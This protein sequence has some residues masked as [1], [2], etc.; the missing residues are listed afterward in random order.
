M[1][2]N[3]GN[4]SVSADSLLRTHYDPSAIADLIAQKNPFFGMLPKKKGMT[5]RTV[6]SFV[7]YGAGGGASSDFSIAQAM[8]KI[9]GNSMAQFAVPLVTKHKVSRVSADL[10]EETESDVGAFMDAVTLI[11]DSD[12]LDFGNQL[13]IALLRGTSGARGQ[14]GSTTTIASATLVLATLS[15]VDQFEVGQQL[16]AAASEKTGA[17]RPLGSNGHGLYI[18]AIDQTQG[19]LTV[20]TSPVAN[21]AQCNLNDAA[22]GI[23]TIATGDFLYIAGDRNV[24]VNGFS[25][26]CPYGS[27]LS[28]DSFLGVNRFANQTR[29]AGSWVDQSSGSQQ[30][31]AVLQDAGAQVA[32]AKGELTHFVM[33]HK[34]LTDLSKELG[35]ATVYVDVPST[36]AK[37]GYTGIKIS[38]PAGEV[39]CVADRSMPATAIYGMDINELDLLS[40]NE[41][42]YAWAKDGKVWLRTSD[43]AGMEIR[44]YSR[45]NLRVKKPNHMINIKV[46]A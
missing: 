44:F 17:I 46:A 2:S 3:F 31:T 18:V 4:T 38:T 24:S 6:N 41:P 16:Y 40:V 21:A 32:R 13:S 37:V 14:V 25:D 15:D 22:D 1:A 28:N 34:H 42:V 33:N 10:I 39:V 12:L 8:S 23:P 43:D 36:Q 7:N 11:S 27:V 30:M 19:T 9:S 20:G 29:L 45:I 5:G 35:S 26:W